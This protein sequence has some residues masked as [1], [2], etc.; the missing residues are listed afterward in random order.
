MNAGQRFGPVTVV[1]PFKQTWR[2]SGLVGRRPRGYPGD[3]AQATAAELLQHAL[4]LPV[5]DRLALAT[6]LLESVEG[7]DDPEWD[8]AWAVELDRRVRELDEGRARGVPWPEVKAKIEARLARE[9][10]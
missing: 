3:V 1:N 9:T 7:P 4:Q 10:K 2:P 8:D 6:E 5:E